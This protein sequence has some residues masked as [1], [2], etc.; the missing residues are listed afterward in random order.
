MTS[1]N[2][3]CHFGFGYVIFLKL[4]SVEVRMQKQAVSEYDDDGT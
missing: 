1:T 3:A 2:L 4:Q